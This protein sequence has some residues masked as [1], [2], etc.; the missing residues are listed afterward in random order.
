MIIFKHYGQ[1]CEGTF[2]DR[3][4]ELQI[5]E[6]LAYLSIGPK[7]YGATERVFTIKVFLGKIGRIYREQSVK[8]T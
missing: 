3:T 7:Y 2:L 5:V 4:R 6:K 8:T 1:T